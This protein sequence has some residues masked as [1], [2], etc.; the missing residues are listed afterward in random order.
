MGPPLP[1]KGSLRAQ[2]TGNLQ[3]A[4]RVLALKHPQ[5]MYLNVRCIRIIS[6]LFNMQNPQPTSALVHRT[7]EEVSE[8]CISTHCRALTPSAHTWRASLSA[9]EIPVKGPQCG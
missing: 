5:R 1:S 8:I 9:P 3:A 4:P 6:K 7:L 2:M